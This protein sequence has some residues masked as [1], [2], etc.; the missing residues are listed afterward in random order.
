VVQFLWSDDRPDYDVSLV[1]GDL[2]A[3]LHSL[4]AASLAT[5]PKERDAGRADALKKYSIAVGTLDKTGLKVGEIRLGDK[6]DPEPQPNRELYLQYGNETL[7]GLDLLQAAAAAAKPDEAA[8]LRLDALA[9]F[10]RAGEAFIKA[11]QA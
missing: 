10:D 11:I 2:L 1:A 6:Y 9:A 8:Q 3:G 4:L 7:L 5:D